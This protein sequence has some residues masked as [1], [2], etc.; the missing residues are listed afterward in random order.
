VEE[1]FQRIDLEQKGQLDILVN[2]AYSGQ[3]II[4]LEPL[5]LQRSPKLQ[6]TLNF[7]ARVKL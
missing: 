3:S 6:T 4:W 7:A 5:Q 2:N 1:L